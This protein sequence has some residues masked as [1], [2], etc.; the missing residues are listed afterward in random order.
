MTLSLIDDSFNRFKNDQLGIFQ[1][2]HGYKVCSFLA[3]SLVRLSTVVVSRY[4]VCST[5]IYSF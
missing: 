5:Y 4:T 1:A 2:H 3:T